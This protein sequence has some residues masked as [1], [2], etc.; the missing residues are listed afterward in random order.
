MIS[1]MQGTNKVKLLVTWTDAL[2][3]WQCIPYCAEANV[4]FLVLNV[5]ARSVNDEAGGTENPLKD[6]SE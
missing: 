5:N 3:S 6:Y 4:T 2:G 1:T